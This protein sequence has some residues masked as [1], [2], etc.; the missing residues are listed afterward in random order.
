MAKKLF[1]S[2]RNSQ[3]PWFFSKSN[4]RRVFNRRKAWNTFPKRIIVGLR[5]SER[6]EYAWYTLDVLIWRDLYTLF[7]CCIVITSRGDSLW[8]TSTW[9]LHTETFFTKGNISSTFR[10]LFSWWLSRN[11]RKNWNWRDTVVILF[12]N[13]NRLSFFIF[14]HM[15]RIEMAP[16][17]SFCHM[18][19]QQRTDFVNL[20]R[21][22][23]EISNQWILTQSI[24][25][26]LKI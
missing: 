9:R 14:F 1:I 4:K 2:L 16:F 19:F 11:P 25:R 24:K 3:F 13:I 20:S 17:K 21:A 15:A 10:A 23:L 18:N 8:L 12:Y 6:K 5:L 7:R 22:F 26:K